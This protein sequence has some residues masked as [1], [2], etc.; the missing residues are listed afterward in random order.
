MTSLVHN[1]T[2]DTG[3]PYELAS[4]WS[5][6]VDRPLSDDD[7]PGDDEAIIALSG[8]PSLLFLRVPEGKTVKNRVHL[9]LQPS[10]TREEE[11]ERLIGL[12]AKLFDDQRRPDGTGWVVL[13]DPEGNEFCVER[14]AAEKAKTS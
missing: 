4:F 12:G 5:K 8:G 14:S 10:T 3:N 9:D 2:F 1:I 11:V 6:V 7:K 13:T